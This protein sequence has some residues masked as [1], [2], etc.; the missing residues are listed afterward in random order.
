[1]R[2]RDRPGREVTTI[3]TQ[4]QSYS[5]I[6]PVA[7]TTDRPTQPAGSKGRTPYSVLGFQAAQPRGGGGRHLVLTELPLWLN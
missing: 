7:K 3:E 4:R 6:L 1:M 2:R 5:R